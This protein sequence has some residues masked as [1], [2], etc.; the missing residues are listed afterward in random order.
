MINRFRPDKYYD[1]QIVDGNDQVVGNI[2]VKPSGV[3][4]APKHAKIWHGVTLDE[5]AHFMEQNGKTQKK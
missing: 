4:W 2:R 5:F 3:L 1:H